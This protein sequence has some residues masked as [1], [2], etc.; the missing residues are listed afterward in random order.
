M[1]AGLTADPYEGEALA[2]DDGLVVEALAMPS[3]VADA[4]AGFVALHH[5]EHVFVKRKRRRADPD[6]LV[7][8]DPAPRE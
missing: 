6:A 2:G 5:V 3:P 1:I 4:L 7:R 8:R